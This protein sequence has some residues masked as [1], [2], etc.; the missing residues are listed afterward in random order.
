MVM[1][2]KVSGWSRIERHNLRDSLAQVL[3]RR[4]VRRNRAAGNAREHVR[5]LAQRPGACIAV[6]VRGHLGDMLAAIPVLR[7][8]RR[9]YP[10]SR[11]IVITNQYA[12]PAVEWCPYVDQVIGFFR[13]YEG[14]RMAFVKRIWGRISMLRLIARL[15]GKVDV[16]LHL[17]W[18]GGDSLL[19]HELIGAKAQVGFS[20]E[21]HGEVLSINLGEKRPGR[22]F[23]EWNI[24][25]LEPLG[26]EDVAQDMEVWTPPA[27]ERA[28]DLLLRQVP[29]SDGSRFV[30]FH[31]R[32]HWGCVE[33]I[34]Q[35]WAT[36]GDE[37]YRRHGLRTVITGS[38]SDAGLAQ[39]IASHMVNKPIVATGKTSFAELA[40]LYRRSLAVVGVDSIARALCQALKQPC[41]IL[42]EAGEAAWCAPLPDEP[43]VVL[44]QNTAAVS[45]AM[46]GPLCEKERGSCHNP[47]CRLNQQ[48]AIEVA[49]VV[50]AVEQLLDPRKRLS[51]ALKPDRG[52]AFSGTL[53]RSGIGAN[54]AGAALAAQHSLGATPPEGREP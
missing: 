21:A 37:I 14:R 48:A 3:V 27:D 5:S 1:L 42:Y 11:I 54:G 25:V 20:Q 8:I 33:W 52:A 2:K 45:L 23:R 6:V 35:R 12:L 9:R 17:R 51:V 31:P 29:A 39:Q 32:A 15:F 10:L 4:A 46:A 49:D 44:N 41:V 13:F 34:P 19:M 18:V 24:E 43:I 36:L 28:V 22:S 7:A 16:S 47:L 30:C 26:L 53:M 50:A 38:A 40:V